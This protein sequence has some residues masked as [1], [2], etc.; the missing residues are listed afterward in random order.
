MGLSPYQASL[1]ISSSAWYGDRPISKQ[2][3]FS[4]GIAD[5][6]RYVAYVQ[7]QNDEGG[8]VEA[9]PEKYI[10]RRWRRDIMPIELQNSRQKICDVD[11]DQCRLLNDTYDVIDDV[12]DILRYD[13]EKIASFLSSIKPKNGHMNQR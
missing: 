6:E 2:S 4:N 10:L 11:E 13:K 3:G 7:K 12:F 8:G 5:E 9:I 1:H